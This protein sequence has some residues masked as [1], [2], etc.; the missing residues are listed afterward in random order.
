MST[1]PAHPGSPRSPAGSESDAA[2][3]LVA[4][5]H[6]YPD[7]FG[8]RRRITL[9]G[10]DLEVAPGTVLGLAGPNGSGKSTLLRVLCGLEPHR[11]GSL[12]VLGGHP[13]D[14]AVRSA[15]GWLPEDSPFP[16]ELTARA[17]LDLAGALQGLRGKELAREV[18]RLLSLVGL[19]ERARSRLGGYSRGMLRR[20]GLAQAWIARPKLLLLDE[21]TAGLD[22]QGFEVL[23]A[24]LAEA[25]SNGTTVVLASHLL[26]DLLGQCD[27]LCVLLDG[28][29]AER[30]APRAIVGA[31]TLLDVYR[32]HARAAGGAGSSA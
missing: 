9:R 8:R 15:I 12:F 30:G 1:S 21:P 19:A 2:V 32:R 25:R 27:E 13:L 5:T 29:I 22:A 10:I 26:T 3:R 24:V 28:R 16:P 20:F 23:D 17:T 6:A 4:L 18:D 11:T 7:F 14:R 31:G